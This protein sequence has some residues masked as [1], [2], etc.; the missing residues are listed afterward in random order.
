MAK[1]ENIK[2]VVKH[3][4]IQAATAVVMAMRDAKVGPWL[5]TVAS[6]NRAQME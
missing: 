5:T 1:S 4:A 2:E 3:M 6:H